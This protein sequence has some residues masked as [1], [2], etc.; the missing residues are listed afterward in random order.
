MFHALREAATRHGDRLALLAARHLPEVKLDF[1]RF[2]LDTSLFF[3][4]GPREG[5][6]FTAR[7][8]LVVAT[9]SPAATLKL[10]LGGR[11]K[12]VDIPAAYVDFEHTQ[13]RLLGYLGALL[14]EGGFSLIAAPRLPAKA[15]AAHAGLG[16]NGRNNTVLV[17]G[18]GSFLTL[19]L[20]FS[21]LPADSAR[22]EPF[23]WAECCAGCQLC[24][25]ACP[26]GALS[27]KSE[28]VV[29]DRCLTLINEQP[30]DFPAWA[31][32]AWHN[33]LIGCTGCQFV[34][35]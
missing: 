13:K 4:F 5:L 35:P 34:C 14:R 23:A 26:S 15:I 24:L 12:A 25:K 8:V 19:S 20:F 31:E 30:G 28:L 17:E 7:S 9:P 10:S 6:G 27:E 21:D 22:F 16:R 2:G 29:I 32:P 1:E 11:V 18:M 33:A 3:D